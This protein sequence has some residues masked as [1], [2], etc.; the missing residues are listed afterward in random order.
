MRSAVASRSA[1]RSTSSRMPRTIRTLRR[2]EYLPNVFNDVRLRFGRIRSTPYE[3]RQQQCRH[4]RDR[5]DDP[6]EFGRSIAAHPE[7]PNSSP[8][9]AEHGIRPASVTHTAPPPQG[10]RPSRQAQSGGRIEHGRPSLA[11][12]RQHRA[13]PQHS[14]PPLEL[15]KWVMKAPWAGPTRCRRAHTRIDSPVVVT[16]SY[17]Q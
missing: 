5:H 11:A 2:F 17:S 8:R 14:P 13:S 4:Q 15:S 6:A 16:V 9:T 7:L 10:R 1:H 3:P 12:G